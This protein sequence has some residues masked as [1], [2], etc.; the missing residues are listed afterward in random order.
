MNLLVPHEDSIRKNVILQLESRKS[1]LSKLS[2][3]VKP[4]RTIVESS[5]LVEEDSKSEN[6]FRDESIMQNLFP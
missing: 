5:L 6:D 4:K 1:N 2:D 3:R